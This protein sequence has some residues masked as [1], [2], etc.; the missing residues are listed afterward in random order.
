MKN[1]N[2]FLAF[3]LI[4]SQSANAQQRIIRGVVTDA[5]NSVPLEG[6]HI[7]AQNSKLESGSQTDGIFTIPV[8]EK[9][10][11]LVFKYDSYQTQEIRLS[12]NDEINV[13]LRKAP[14]PVLVPALVAGTWRGLFTI[15]PGVQ[16]P[17]HF[18]VEQDGN[19]FL[20]NG[21]ERFPAG[22]F[23]IEGDSL[24][25]P[26]P[27]F[28]NEL[29][30]G[31]QNG[32]LNG[33]LRRQ[34]LR[35][36]P[37]PVKAEKGQ[38]Y[39]FDETGSAATKDITGTY[40]V[41]FGNGERQEKAV[42]IFKQQGNKLT[43]TF[44][45]VT[46]DSRFLEG[47]IEDNKI[48]LSAFIGSSPSYYTAV[49]N[50]DGSLS[51]ENVNARGAL[52]FKATFNKNAALPDA[53]A[54]TKLKEGNDRISFSFPDAEG[55]TVSSSD[56]RF[57]GKPLIISIGGTWCPNCMDEAAFLGPWY[58]KNKSRGIEVIALQYERQTD[59]A[60]VKKTFNRFQKQYSLNYTLLLGGVADK[61]AVVASL[62]ALQNFVSFPTT[63]FVDRNG[64]VAKIHTGFSGPATGEHYEAFIK[65]FNEEVNSLLK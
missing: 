55:K 34:D 27:L 4:L 25:V 49:I 20:L 14:N 3:V 57:A 26:F 53:Y 33:I 28:E 32:T 23:R 35:G 15:K 45:R 58:E 63:I 44:L 39:R 50:A 52:P 18:A 36:N 10:S 29:A 65:E 56:A 54:L 40:D 38:R 48:Q 16:V 13:Q 17:F 2:L 24:F 7:L 41:V 59:A 43:A 31:Y 6:V 19:V 11:I 22:P 1:A 30:L 42:G 5:L 47:T 12:G 61:Q 62:P 60:F 64:K 37:T 46:G 8:S 21:D 9:D 51:G